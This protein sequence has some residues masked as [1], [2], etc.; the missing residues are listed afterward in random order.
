MQAAGTS[1]VFVSSFHTRLISADLRAPVC[2]C[3]KWN[4][5]QCC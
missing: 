3:V 4:S 5:R 2:L 1:E